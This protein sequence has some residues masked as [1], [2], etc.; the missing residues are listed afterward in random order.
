MKMSA[1]VKEHY[2]HF[3]NDFSPEII[4]FATNTALESS[5][6]LFV[7]TIKNQQYGYCTHC[8]VE[9]P[10][11]LPKLSDRAIAE[12]EMCGCPAAL[13]MGE[14]YERKKHGEKAICPNCKSECIVR[15]AGLGH[16]NLRDCAYFV[17]YEKSK[18][19]SNI[20]VARG[21]HAVRYYGN[22]Y[23]NVQTELETEV[24]YSF[25]YKKMGKMIKPIS[26]PWGHNH[27]GFSKTIHSW[28]NRHGYNTY[29]CY[30]RKSI[31]NAVKNTPFAWIGWENYDYN[32]M[33]EYFDLFSRYP[34][35]EYLNKLGYKQLVT[36]KLETKTISKGA[37]NWNGKTIEGVFRLTKEEYNIVK[38]YKI[39]VT[40]SFLNLTKSVKER[41]LNLTIPEISDLSHII[42]SYS[43]MD[44]ELSSINKTFGEYLNFKDAFRYCMKQN[45]KNM[46]TYNS[47]YSITSAWR[48]YV[49]ECKKL[50]MDIS[51]M[52]VLFPND[53]H[54]AHQNT[55]DQIRYEVDKALTEKIVS[56]LPTMT[57]FYITSDKY[58]IRPAESAFEIVNEGRELHHCVGRYAKDYAD[59]KTCILFI[60]KV[61]EPD[62]PFYTVEVNGREV[63]QVRG[64]QNCAPKDEMLLAFIKRFTKEAV[65]LKKSNRRQTK[66]KIPA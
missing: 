62:K 3:D 32:D 26:E 24:H 33:V 63:V 22:G 59:G 30:S 64:L 28:A 52:R 15:Y 53:L 11:H 16:S 44:N 21:I 18:L 1:G 55:T 13:Y 47:V 45:N 65:A 25:E 9:L 48:D 38:Q 37:I 2:L 19:D 42:P 58:L 34:V 6:Y 39:N 36:E 27:I 43:N 35:I 51:D 54:K 7:T 40:S 41:E 31:K 20:L 8:N 66:N 4:E 46:S 57:R 60:R 12:R 17:Y 49:S 14:E 50:N 23:K 10:T 29:F 5:K 61:E 56:R